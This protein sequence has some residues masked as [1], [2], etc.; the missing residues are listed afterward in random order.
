M[1]TL[2]RENWN[3]HPVS[4][5]DGWRLAKV[6]GGR[7]RHA[8]CEL[9]SHQFGWELRLVT[10][11]GEFQRSQV[12]RSQDGVLSVTAEWKAAML[13]KGWV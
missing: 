7:Q 5:G 8:V 6:V 11:G 4:L 9:W 10:D 3:G 1:N 12:C 13:G 2:Q